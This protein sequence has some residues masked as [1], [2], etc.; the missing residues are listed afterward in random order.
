M[1]SRCLQTG[2]QEQASQ[3]LKVNKGEDWSLADSLGNEL[4]EACD[5]DLIE[6][7]SL[8]SSSHSSSGIGPKPL[9]EGWTWTKHVL[10]VDGCMGN[11]VFY[12]IWHLCSRAATGKCH[13]RA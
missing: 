9:G 8:D 2:Q 13:C 12:G 10:F 3:A 1:L 4:R 5:E 7:I 6:R 11:P